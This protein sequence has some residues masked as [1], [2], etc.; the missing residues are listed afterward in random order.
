VF[1]SNLFHDFSGKSH[2]KRNGKWQ[3]WNGSFGLVDTGQKKLLVTCGHVVDEFR[4]RASNVAD[5]KMCVCL[6]RKNP[7][8]LDIGCLIDEDKSSDLASFDLRSLLPACEGRSFHQLTCDHIRKVEKGDRLVFVGYPG[9]LR[10]ET[11]EGIYFGTT[12]HVVIAQDVSA[13]GVI[14]DLSRVMSIDRVLL[15]EQNENPLGGVSGSPCFLMQDYTYL[16]LIGFVT[17]EMRLQKIL[18]ICSAKFLNADG[19]IK[20]H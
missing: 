18:Q 2:R 20:R 19:T 9:Y 11:D 6:D 14:C 8:V 7:V 13:F 3:F 1:W 10:K 12:P 15:S 4:Q 17:G 16:H 5:L